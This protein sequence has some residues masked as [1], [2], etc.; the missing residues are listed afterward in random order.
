MPNTYYLIGAE[1]AAD[2]DLR[3][4]VLDDDLNEELDDYFDFVLMEKDEF[5]GPTKTTV[6]KTQEKL[7]DEM[8]VMQETKSE[9]IAANLK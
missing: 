3:K 8:A 2:E 5:E 6:K 4:S 1:K 9:L 7:V